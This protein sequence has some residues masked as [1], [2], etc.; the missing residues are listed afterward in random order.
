MTVSS[1]AHVS[2]EVG[3]FGPIPDLLDELEVPAS[4]IVNASREN[5]NRFLKERGKNIPEI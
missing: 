3:Y 2:Y 1:D 4:L 5:L